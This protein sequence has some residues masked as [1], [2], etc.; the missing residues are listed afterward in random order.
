MDSLSCLYWLQICILSSR[1]SSVVC[2][3]LV[4][5]SYCLLSVWPALWDSAVFLTVD[6]VDLCFQG[7]KVKQERWGINTHVEYEVL[8]KSLVGPA[9]PPHTSRPY[10][11]LQPNT[12][13]LLA[14]TDE[15]N[16]HILVISY[17]YSVPSAGE[18]DEWN[19]S[20]CVVY[21]LA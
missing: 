18:W 3:L 13:H 4:G 15:C 5:S 14:A 6:A 8:F 10:F 9:Q 21:R 19:M 11:P 12:H 16:C 20:V 7:D 2:S 17:L 1:L